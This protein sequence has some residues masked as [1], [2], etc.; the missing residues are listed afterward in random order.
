M[1]GRFPLRMPQSL[2]YKAAL[3]AERDGVDLNL[4]ITASIARHLGM[5]EAMDKIEMNKVTEEN[6]Q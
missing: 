4:F 5:L 3:L 1:S 6:K 2:H